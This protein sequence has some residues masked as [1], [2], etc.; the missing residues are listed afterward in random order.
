MVKDKNNP[1]KFIKLNFFIIILCVCL[2]IAPAKNE[3][4]RNA[5]ISLLDGTCKLIYCSDEEYED[6]TCT[7]SNQIIKTQ[8]LSN[9]IKI[10]DRDFRYVNFAT[11]SNGDMLVETTAYPGNKFRYFFG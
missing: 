5:P 3:C 11:Y 4:E 2:L 8:W 7:V 10:G 9:I 6:N 1:F